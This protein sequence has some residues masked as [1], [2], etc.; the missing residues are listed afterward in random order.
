MQ[1]DPNVLQIK[2]HLNDIERAF[3]PTG[4]TGGNLRA[5]GRRAQRFVALGVAVL[6]VS[7][8]SLGGIL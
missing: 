8:V 2:A 7:L 5:L 4:R 1:T 3:A 6:T